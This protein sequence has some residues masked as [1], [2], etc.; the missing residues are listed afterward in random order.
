MGYE[1]K[2]EVLV[3]KS[4]RI[5][6]DLFTI[7]SYEQWVKNPSYHGDYDDYVCHM[8]NEQHIKKKEMLRRIIREELDRKNNDNTKQ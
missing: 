7:K 3:K 5:V 8:N 6:S 2:E 1:E 4:L